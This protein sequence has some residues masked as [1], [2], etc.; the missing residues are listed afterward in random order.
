MT[1][2]TSKWPIVVASIVAWIILLYA[3]VVSSSHIIETALKVGLTGWTAWTAPVLVDAVAI[4]GKLGRLERFTDE[5]RRSSLKLFTFG[6]HSAS[7]ATCTPARTSASRSTA[8]SSWSSWSG[9][10]RTSPR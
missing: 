3:I 2:N 6:G 4:V 7:P 10:S 8:L 1:S 5:T 9:S